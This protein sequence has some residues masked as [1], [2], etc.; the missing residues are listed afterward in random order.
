MTD[1]HAFHSEVHRIASFAAAV[2]TAVRPTQ[3]ADW[4]EQLP[5]LVGARVTLREL[6][7][8]D[9]PALYDHLTTEDVARFISTPPGDIEGFERFIC[10][11]QCER[12]RGRGACYAVVPHGV[13]TAVGLFQLRCVDTSFATAEWGF[14]IGAAYWG[15]GCFTDAARM[16]VDFAIETIG[17]RRLEARSAVSNGRGNGA[18][19]KLGAVREGVL[20]QG[21]AKDGQAMDSTIWSI[22]ADEWRRGPALATPSIVH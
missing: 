10:W 16:V 13:S 5:S 1:R 18:L 3:S 22:L 21:F 6:K 15:T 2:R 9:A 20:R 19:R 7:L 11:S 17:V 4:R 12:A 14:A 8:A